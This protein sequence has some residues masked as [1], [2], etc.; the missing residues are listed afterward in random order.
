MATQ[1]LWDR[2]L[3]VLS[4]LAG[5]AI[6]WGARRWRVRKVQVTVDM[7]GDTSIPPKSALRCKHCGHELVEG[8]EGPGM[9][10]W[11]CPTCKAWWSWL[12]PPN[13]KEK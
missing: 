3:N 10:T 1:D 6:G 2:L 8:S 9:P 12:Y 13:Q 4:G 7:G 5:I 11:T